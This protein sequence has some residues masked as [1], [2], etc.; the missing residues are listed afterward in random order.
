MSHTPGPWSVQR[1]PRGVAFFIGSEGEP[2]AQH[3]TESNANLIAAA[4][5]LLNALREFLDW[6]ASEDSVDAEMPEDLLVKLQQA[7]KKAEGV[8]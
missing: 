2:I 8:A 4:P 1:Q 6:L 7:V 3:V 5:D